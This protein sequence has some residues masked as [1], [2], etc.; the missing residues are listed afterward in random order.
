MAETN[1]P[2][3]DMDQYARYK[4]ILDVAA[5][6]NYDLN[7]AAKETK[8]Y[9]DTYINSG[10]LK[11]VLLRNNWF[12]EQLA[13]SKAEN[14]CLNKNKAETL[15]RLIDNII[16]TGE[17]K[18][19]V[20]SPSVLAKFLDIRLKTLHAYGMDRSDESDTPQARLSKAQME[21]AR[22]QSLRLIKSMEKDSAK[23]G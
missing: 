3:Q 9:S 12:V 4:A 16:D 23:A 20:I 7:A 10:T 8:L 17:Y 13:K 6:H 14:L 11:R 1:Q 18:G 2:R 21:S 5:K 22:K 19:Q 15:Y